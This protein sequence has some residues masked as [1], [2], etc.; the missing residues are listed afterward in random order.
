[1]KRFNINEY[2]YTN[3][4][5]HLIKQKKEIIMYEVKNINT[6][7]LIKTTKSI[8]IARKIRAKI[9]NVR[10]YDYGT[11]HTVIQCEAKGGM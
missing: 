10:I 3:Y 5:N 1:M 7:K 2:D 8:D 6:Y 9:S 4:I 11:N